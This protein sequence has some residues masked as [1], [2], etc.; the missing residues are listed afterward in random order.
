VVC[1]L[2]SMVGSKIATI[3]TDLQT[4]GGTVIDS[5]KT[6]TVT[7][8][9][10]SSATGKLTD[11]GITSAQCYQT[12]SNT[13]VSCTSAAAIALN[14][15]QDGMVGR[16]VSS[17]NN[18]DGKLG[19]NYSTVGSY[20]TTDCVKDNITG[21]TWEGKDATFR[22]RWGGNVYTNYGNGH[23]DDA[24]TYVTAVNAIAL[25]GYSDWRL[26]TASELQSLVDFGVAYPGPTI[27][28]A[29]FPNTFG[30]LWSASP[31][32]TDPSGAWVVSFT[33]GSV[34]G[35]LRGDNRQV[36]LVR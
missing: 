19:F 14:A 1:T 23:R 24:S 27:D 31:F 28:A 13:L 11:T 21:L 26:P 12:G 36:R 6:I 20:A 29:W 10:V 15:S 2:G 32:M 18:T 4:N 35:S 25:C 8:V 33:D 16:D 7:T 9:A 3:K 22:L 17:P 34:Y 5:T 30:S